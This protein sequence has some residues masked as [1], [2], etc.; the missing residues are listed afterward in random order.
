[1]ERRSL[2]WLGRCHAGIVDARSYLRG[3]LEVVSLSYFDLHD[4]G[5]ESIQVSAAGKKVM[6]SHVVTLWRACLANKTGA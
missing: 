5:E 3:A 1:M 2:R 6:T 4:A